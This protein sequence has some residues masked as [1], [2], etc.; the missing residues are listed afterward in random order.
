[1]IKAAAMA[2]DVLDHA[3]F[4]Y[5]HRRTVDGNE[6]SSNG[7]VRCDD[8]EAG[9]GLEQ[10]NGLPGGPIVLPGRVA[11]QARRFSR[12]GTFQQSGRGGALPADGS[13]SPIA[14]IL[15]HRNRKR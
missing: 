6:C 13:T 8:D 2:A 14:H 12:N 9:A 4:S 11:G 5:G 1:L 15:L 10:P 7:R 3:A